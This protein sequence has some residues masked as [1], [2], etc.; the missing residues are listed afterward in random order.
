MFHSYLY[1]KYF[2]VNKC[3]YLPNDDQTIKFGQIHV[4]MLLSSDGNTVD[5]QI[6]SAS[7]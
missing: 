6:Q 7:K 1:V 4:Q 5:M 2:H 3:V